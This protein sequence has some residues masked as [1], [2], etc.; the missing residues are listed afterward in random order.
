MNEVFRDVK[1]TQH[2]GFS[3]YKLIIS[4]KNKEC[5]LRCFGR[6]NIENYLNRYD[7]LNEKIKIDTTNTINKKIKTI[8]NE[9]NLQGKE[10]HK[11]IIS[12][13][14]KI[15]EWESFEVVTEQKPK[16]FNNF[17]YNPDCL[18]YKDGDLYLAI[19]V[20][21]KGSIEKDKDS[22]KLLKN[23]GARKVILVSD[24][25]KLDRVRKLFMYNGDIKSWT[26]FWSFERVLKMYD[27]G[28]KFFSNFK[29]FKNYSYN[30]N[31][32]EYL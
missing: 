14:K 22:L 12:M 11:L 2:D 29:K 13:L 15:G 20:C 28:E 30:E 6:Y 21:H 5:F 9:T 4:I 32:V 17:P 27:E 25:S 3:Q 26:E 23:L 16:H 7:L 31:I 8:A 24:L 18:W 19:E 1:A 10:F